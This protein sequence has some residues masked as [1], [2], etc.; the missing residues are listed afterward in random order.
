MSGS[1]KASK[2]PGKCW[3]QA[4]AAEDCARL[5]DKAGKKAD[6][7]EQGTKAAEVRAGVATFLRTRLIE[8]TCR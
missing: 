8:E 4:Q 3:T 5:C 7:W 6:G 2:I 1:F